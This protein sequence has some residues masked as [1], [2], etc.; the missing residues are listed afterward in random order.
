MNYISPKMISIGDKVLYKGIQYDVLI[1][2]IKGEIDRKGYNPSYNYSI[3]IDNNDNR[4]TCLDYKQLDVI[5][6]F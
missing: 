5:E 4:I 2:Y 6:L 1:N 3:L